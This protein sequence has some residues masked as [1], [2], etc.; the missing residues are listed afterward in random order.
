MDKQQ[1]IEQLSEQLRGT[2]RVAG[3]AKVDAANEARFGATAAEKRADA[4]VAIE[5]AN[6]AR[7]Q[8]R[9]ELRARGELE[10]LARFSPGSFTERAPIAVG[11]IVEVEDEESGQGR[12][13]FLAPVGAGV[14]L[15]GPDGDGVLSVVTP[16]SPVGRAVL[17]RRLGDEIDVTVKGETREWTITYVG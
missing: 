4:R 1:L 10:A 5:Y 6:L 14:T 13:F 7:A 9:R 12:T 15:T 16:A 2:A 17:G 11:A 3:D 8:A